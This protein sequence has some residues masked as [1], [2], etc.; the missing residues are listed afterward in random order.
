M[1]ALV[2]LAGL[3]AALPAAAQ[4]VNRGRELVQ[5][6]AGEVA[7]CSSC[8]GMDGRGQ[9]PGAIPRLDG[10]TPFYLYKQLHDFASGERPSDVMTPIAQGLSEQQR[11]DAAAYFAAQPFAAGPAPTAGE[12]ERGR[13]IYEL[14]I[15]GQG[16]QACANCH[17]P[18]GAGIGPLNPRLLGQWAEY[19]GL[20]L[21]SFRERQRRNDPAGVMRSIAPRL[22]DEDIRAVGAWLER[23]PP[24]PR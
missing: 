2:L 11:Q 14:G 10:Q 21:T 9:G 19:S 16:V 23:A 12:A 24:G 15:A 13:R 4:D 1:R 6:G 20:Q 8:H 18:E 3:C 7:P 22:T 5:D 17:G